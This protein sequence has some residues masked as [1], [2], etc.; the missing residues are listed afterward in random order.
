MMAL[1]LQRFNESGPNYLPKMTK[2]R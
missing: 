2:K 1:D